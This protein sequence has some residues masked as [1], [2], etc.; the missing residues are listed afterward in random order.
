[1][2]WRAEG[3]LRNLATAIDQCS[4]I[5]AIKESILL[6][7]KAFKIL[8]PTTETEPL[9]VETD[10]LLDDPNDLILDDL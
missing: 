9:A 10:H 3:G 1:V 2:K 4:D 7:R 6:L 8:K 5:D